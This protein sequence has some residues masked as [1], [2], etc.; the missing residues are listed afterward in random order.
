MPEEMAVTPPPAPPSSCI[1]RS[2]VVVRV[3]FAH[4]T[5]SAP[6]QSALAC[7]PPSS[8]AAGSAPSWSAAR[9]VQAISSSR[10]ACSAC[11]A[12]S[13]STRRAPSCTRSW[14]HARRRRW[15][16]WPGPITGTESS[17]VRRCS[18]CARS[19]T[20]TVTRS[21]AAWAAATAPSSSTYGP[22]PSQTGCP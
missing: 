4:R 15:L 3:R 14:H 2:T 1:L 9:S 18:S 19:T 22:L 5:P 16:L 6:V 12:T 20:T 17:C 10:P 7:S 8:S 21:R 13:T 11:C